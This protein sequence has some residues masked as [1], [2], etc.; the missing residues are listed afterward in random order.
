MSTVKG[1]ELSGLSADEVADRVLSLASIHLDEERINDIDNLEML[2]VGV[3]HLYLQRS[4]FPS[5]NPP[6]HAP[7]AA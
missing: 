4:L 3:T 2:G 7:A 5:H 1:D 6:N